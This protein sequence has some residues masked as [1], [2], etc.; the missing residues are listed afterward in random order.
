MF[1]R[2]HGAVVVVLLALSM[3]SGCIV[4][5]DD[6][7]GPAER[8]QC[9]SACENLVDICPNEGNFEDLETCTGE[10]REDVESGRYGDETLDCFE[11]ASTC[12]E[13]RACR[14]ERPRDIGTTDGGSQ[15]DARGDDAGTDG[16][17]QTDARGDDAATDGSSMTD[18][19]PDGA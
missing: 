5:L 18:G 10:C 3:A 7:S 14:P 12:D 11:R 1:E 6:D 15:S 16:G 4:D 17:P 9:R 13:A 19:A 8:L 2:L